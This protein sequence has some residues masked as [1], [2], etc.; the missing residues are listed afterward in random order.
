MDAVRV[1]VWI[2]VRVITQTQH[3][4]RTMKLCEWWFTSVMSRED[5]LR[6]GKGDLHQQGDADNDARYS[7]GTGA[8]ED[9]GSRCPDSS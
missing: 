4:Q 8:I 6:R 7:W 3:Q 5:M 2:W 9:E 1:K